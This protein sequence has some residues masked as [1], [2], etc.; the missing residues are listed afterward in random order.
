MSAYRVTKCKCPNCKGTGQSALG[1][2][3]C[4]C[5]GAGK[6]ARKDALHWADVT[7]TFAGGGYIA[8]DYDLA[9]MRDME[10]KAK[11]V[12]EML[13]EPNRYRRKAA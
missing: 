7:W 2:T 5:H 4:Y 11:A 13:G 6:A 8:G 3:C 10:A 12:A 9:E 1:I